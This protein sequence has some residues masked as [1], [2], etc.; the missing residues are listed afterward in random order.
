[1]TSEKKGFLSLLAKLY[2]NGWN[3]IKNTDYDGRQTD[4][5]KSFI[6]NRSDLLRNIPLRLTGNY[7]Y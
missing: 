6:G 2:K 5:N 3:T 7:F 1:M 4:G